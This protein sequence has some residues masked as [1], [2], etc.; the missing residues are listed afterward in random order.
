MKRVL[1]IYYFYGDQ[2]KIASV[3]GAGLVKY[4]PKFGWTPYIITA[5]PQIEF[6]PE[7]FVIS[8]PFEDMRKKWKNRLG[9]NADLSLRAGLNIRAKKNEKDIIDLSIRALGEIIAYP[10]SFTG[11]KKSV[12]RLA[13][14]LIERKSFDAMISSSGPPTSN[15]IAKYLKDNYSIPWVA[16]F[17]DL[18]TQNHRYLY[19]N[20]RRSFE[21]RL[22]I[23]TL[24]SADALTTVSQPLAYK[25]KQLHSRKDVYTI[26]NGFDPLQKNPGLPLADRFT[27]THTGHINRGFQDPEPLFEAIGSLISDGLIDRREIS[28]DFFGQRDY[29]LEKDAAKHK[30]GDIVRIFGSVSRTEAIEMQRR[31]HLLLLLIWNDS[32]EKGI[33]TGKVFEYLAAQ[34]PILAIGYKGSVIDN[35][36]LE[37]N[38]G[39]QCSIADEIKNA[40][41]KAYLEFKSQGTVNYRGIYSSVEKYSH[42]EMAKKFANVLDNLLQ[43]H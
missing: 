33:Y 21:R 42:I 20:M 32:K 29:W 6:P 41:Y 35:L 15:L 37:T 5:T 34:R 10:D 27:I 25:L 17:R 40:V 18:W 7:E 43:N 28:I 13:S 31:S 23:K 30:I 39:I 14:D 11:W 1:V 16:D 19:S 38:A 2:R 4:L 3:R 12:I 36:L 22:E 24:S 26:P 9:L 8:V